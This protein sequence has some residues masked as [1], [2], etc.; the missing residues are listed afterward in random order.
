MANRVS[1]LLLREFC[2]GQD[3]SAGGLLLR[4][5]HSASVLSSHQLHTDHNYV[6]LEGSFT[7]PEFSL[8]FLMYRKL[9]FRDLAECSPLAC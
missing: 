5:E 9:F 3:S 7:Q 4:D 2:L 8:S 1:G 6:A